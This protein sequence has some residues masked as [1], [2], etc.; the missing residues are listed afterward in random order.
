MEIIT[1]INERLVSHQAIAFPST[2][3]VWKALLGLLCLMLLKFMYNDFSV[4][5]VQSF[6]HV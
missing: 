6:S 4:V 1:L 5:V 2:L 3:G